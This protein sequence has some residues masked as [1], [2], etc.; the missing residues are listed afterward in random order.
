MFSRQASYRNT[1][2]MMINDLKFDLFPLI[3]KLTAVKEPRANHVGVW[4]LRSCA[5]A[6][7]IFR[8]KAMDNGLFDVRTIP[9]ASSYH[10]C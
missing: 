8:E 2:L 6:C 9:F 5:D 3:A 4:L 1:A 7:D 10:M